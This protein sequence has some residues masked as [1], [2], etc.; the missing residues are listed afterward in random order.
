MRIAWLTSK[1][2]YSGSYFV[3]LIRT[4]SFSHETLRGI[5]LLA[6]II[7]CTF[8]SFGQPSDFPFGQISY[9]EL[10]K[11]VFPLDTNANAIVLNEFGEA[12]INPRDF[13]LNFK[14]HVKIKILKKAGLEKGNF[15]IALRKN[16][17]SEELLLDIKAATFNLENNTIIDSRFERKDLFTETRNEYLKVK[18]LALPNVKTG[19]IVEVEY[20]MESPFV[21]NFRE[22]EFQS[23]IPKLKS[24]Y[25]ANIPGNYL[26]N[27]S[28]KGFLKLSKN[29]STLVKE[30]LIVGSGK[31][32]C[33]LYKYAMVNI[34]AFIEE[35]FA[36]ASSNFIAA[37][38]IELTEIRHFDGRID[39]VTK[40]WSDVDDELRRDQSFG[41][42]L[43]R[44]KDIAG[45]IEKL[46][47]PSDNNL[48]RANKVYDFI[49]DWYSWNGT[50]GKYSEFGIKKAFDSRKG[51]VGDINLSLI[52]ALRFAGLEAE[53]VVLSTRAN[54]TAKDIHPVLS[55]FNYV[56][57]KFDHE[58]TTYLLDATD[59]FMPF[60]MLPERCL[61]GKGRVL[62]GKKSY[63]INIEP[64]EKKKTI[65]AVKL[66]LDD[67]GFLRG[68][69]QNIY[70]GYEAAAQ[71]KIVLGFSSLAE[72]FKDLD[73][74]WAHINIIN[75]E[76]ENLDDFVKPL[77]EKL[78]VEIKVF[79]E[80]SATSFF[81][82]PFIIQQW[83][84]NPFQST[85][86]LYPV[87]F[88]YPLEWTLSVILELPTHIQLGEAPDPLALNLRDK[89]GFYRYQATQ[90]GN[91]VSIQSSLVI[92]RTVFKADEYN[93]LKELFARVIQSQNIDLVFVKK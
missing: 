1:I 25:W 10:S 14:Y 47:K 45:E 26:Y 65:S 49:K 37:I 12:Y 30:C 42:Q 61:N 70:S 19:S 89:G 77:T 86:R 52:A 6:L 40:E 3:W 80:L 38:N 76:I 16:G 50:Y 72:Y 34:P 81:F 92:N 84:K 8:K 29:E 66:K 93:N 85:N 28:L 79:D 82:N 60:G 32:D 13:K 63:W 27:I 55:D 58:G 54:G 17:S 59:D 21:M 91:Q 69:I 88:A 71:R 11:E 9:A 7:F 35:E 64:S 15:E 48:T 5:S 67:D 23:D 73:N 20:T 33:A 78:T 53:P 43:K 51:N 56:V 4:N 75:A 83:K 31:A 24:E 57:A 87:D 2:H 74:N 18:K 39:K 36:T 90:I 62:E 46:I 68:S 41:V 44:G 22:W